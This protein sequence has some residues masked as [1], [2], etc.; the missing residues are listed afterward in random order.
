MKDEI[1]EMLKI[2]NKIMGDTASMELVSDKY[3]RHP[4]TESK[5]LLT[6]ALGKIL[7]EETLE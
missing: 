2:L 1:I 6:L 3:Y 5:R 7:A 4:I